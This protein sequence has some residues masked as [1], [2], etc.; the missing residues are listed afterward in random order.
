MAKIPNIFF[1]ST[2]R[3]EFNGHFLNKMERYIYSKTFYNKAISE[4]SGAILQ[5]TEIV[6]EGLN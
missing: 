3:S 5:T 1:Q 2:V 6:C 4:L